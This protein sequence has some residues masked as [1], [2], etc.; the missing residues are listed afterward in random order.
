MP[1]TLYAAGTTS[2][3]STQLKR[4]LGYPQLLSQYTEKRNIIN[5]VE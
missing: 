5:W 4:E 1:F 3:E 2:K